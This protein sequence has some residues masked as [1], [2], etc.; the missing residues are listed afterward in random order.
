MMSRSSSCSSL[1]SNLELNDD[2]DFELDFASQTISSFKLR[3]NCSTQMAYFDQLP[4]DQ[5]FAY[6]LESIK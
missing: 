3:I 6:Q 4:N 2:D 1:I 5:S